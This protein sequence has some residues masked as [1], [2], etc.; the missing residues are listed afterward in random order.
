MKKIL[1]SLCVLS[2]LSACA[3]GTPEQHALYGVDDQGIIEIREYIEVS[4]TDTIEARLE[5]IANRLSEIAFANNPI[6][7]S[8]ITQQDGKDVVIIDLQDNPEG[9]IETTWMAG[10]FQG[11]AGAQATETTLVQSFLQPHYYDG[12]WIDGVVFYYEGEPIEPLDHIDF[13]Q[14]FYREQ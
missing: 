7:P 5:K 9:D 1:F 6:T 12:E 8:K 4:S 14:T 10:Y 2:L 13:S 11:S 3:T